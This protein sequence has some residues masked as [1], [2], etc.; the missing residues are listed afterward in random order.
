[1]DQ[2]RRDRKKRIRREI[3]TRDDFTCCDCGWVADTEEWDGVSPLTD[4]NR[5]LTID[6]IIEKAAGGSS[7]KSNFQTLCNRC[8]TKKSVEFGRCVM[9]WLAQGLPIDQA[10]VKA[11]IQLGIVRQDEQ[12]G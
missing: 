8:N 6:H 3:F 9:A 10:R 12:S 7:E 5:T 2:R 4:G 11:A 1:L